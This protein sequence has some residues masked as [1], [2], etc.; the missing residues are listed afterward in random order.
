M[1][2]FLQR[3]IALFLILLSIPVTLMI[4]ILIKIIDGDK[5]F[6][7]QK[8]IGKKGEQFSIYKFRTMVDGAEEMRRQYEHLNEADGPVFKVRND[9]RFTKVGKWLSWSG[10]DELP[11]LVNVL[12]G[13]M[14]LVGPRPF[15][16]YEAEK[17]PAKYRRRQDVLP[18]ITSLWVVGGTHELSFEE[19]MRLDLEYVRKRGLWMDVNVLLKTIKIVVKGVVKGAGNAKKRIS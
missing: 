19:W 10:L 17:V 9:P 11:Q 5:V 13:E 1:N 14:A 15:P 7:L 2:Y 12:K 4:V 6:F 16:V 8:R 18:G 3:L